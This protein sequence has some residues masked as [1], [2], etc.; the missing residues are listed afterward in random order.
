M[1]TRRIAYL[2]AVLFA[3][4]PNALGF[5]TW[6]FNG[7]IT[8]GLPGSPYR[9]GLLWG[10]TFTIDTSRLTTTP[11][12]LYFPTV[13]YGWGA[14][15]SG[16]GASS[17]GSGILVANDRPASGG[18]SFD[19]IIFSFFGEQDTGFSAATPFD[20][21]ADGI[22]LVNTSGGLTATPFS[23]TSFPSTLDLNQFSQRYLDVP[24]QGGSVLGTVDSLT[25]NG[26]LVSKTPEPGVLGLLVLGVLLFGLPAQ[27]N[28]RNKA[29]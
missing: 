17:V 24:F 26:V 11:T 4:L 22:T 15:H 13:N 18:G 16:F 29:A 10:A 9:A 25:I 5:D 6:T 27:I 1:T 20:G 23:D 2:S 28:K 8:T 21:S 19:G 14:A 12:G 7:I 3:I